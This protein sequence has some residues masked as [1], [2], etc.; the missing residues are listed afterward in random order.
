MENIEEV[1]VRQPRSLETPET[2]QYDAD[3]EFEYPKFVSMIANEDSASDPM[4]TSGILPD[5]FRLAA[6]P[7]ALPPS[8]WTQ[9]GCYNWFT[10][11]DRRL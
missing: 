1:S 11:R 3:V 7:L 10:Y 9:F 6:P 2:P 4:H 5:L 8:C